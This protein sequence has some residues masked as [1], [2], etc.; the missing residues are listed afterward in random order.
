MI[1]KFD[2]VKYRYLDK[3]GLVLNVFDYI[4][5]KDYFPMTTCAYVLWGK[6]KDNILIHDIN[7]LVKIC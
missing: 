2:L 7:K 6:D 4:N 1:K 3:I 5:N